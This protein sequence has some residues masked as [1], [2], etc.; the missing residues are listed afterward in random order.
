MPE[1]ENV[2]VDLR[3]LI[4]VHAESGEVLQMQVVVAV[5]FGVL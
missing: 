2:S 3:A 5:D 1:C 4:E